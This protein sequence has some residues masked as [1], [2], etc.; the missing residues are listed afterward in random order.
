M[1]S[2]QAGT[3][4]LFRLNSSY[5]IADKQHYVNLDRLRIVR[6]AKGPPLE[7]RLDLFL[8]PLPSRTERVLSRSDIV[9][10]RLVRSP[11]RSSGGAGSRTTPSRALRWPLHESIQRAL[12]RA[13]R[14]TPP[15]GVLRRG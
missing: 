8:D 5:S 13:S 12:T 10:G 1:V 14:S 6:R 3:S 7:H 15:I 9:Y 4:S 2:R 11:G